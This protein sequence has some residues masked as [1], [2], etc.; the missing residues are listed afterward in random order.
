[1]T[2]TYN[3]QRVRSE[4]LSPEVLALDASGTGARR[5]L[6]RSMAARAPMFTKLAC[7]SAIVLTCSVLNGYTQVSNV[8]PDAFPGAEGY[9][10][11]AQAGRGGAVIPVTN[12]E[13]RGSGS[14][15]ECIEA[16]GP[17]NCVFRVGGVIK[18]K[19]TLLGRSENG[20]IS[21]LGQTAP[22]DGIV[23]TIEQPQQEGRNTPLAFKGTSDVLIRHI[24]V[25]PR[26]PN[27]VKN[28]D[29]LTIENSQR[30]YVDHVSASWAT[31]ENINTYSN[32]TDVTIANSIFAEGLNKHSKC[33]LLG[34]DPRTPQNLTFLRN[35]CLSNRD[36]NPDNNHYGHSCI[37]IVNNVFFNAQSEWAEVFSQYPGGTPIA[38]AGNYFKAGPSTNDLTY[39]IKAQPYARVADPHIYQD[40]N[41]TWAPPT[42]T[43]VTVAPETERFLV[44]S[45]P[46]P[47]SVSGIA[48]AAKAYDEVRTR[49]GA[50]PRD[51]LDQAWID[52]MGPAGQ[53]GKGRMV[54]APGQLP[55]MQGGA[56]YKD[57]D[58]DGMADSVEAQ[59]G[60]RPG[61][62][63]AW[64]TNTP[65]GPSH[66][67]AFMAWLSEERIAGRYPR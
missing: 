16:T 4:L 38:F 35:L 40:G 63:D 53:N 61:V 65:D 15:R 46:C 3:Q 17:R 67:D 27:T 44:S 28:V 24:R 48:P 14:L 62:S 23:L 47:L 12:L 36:R 37:E 59:F 26:L 50:F 2:A 32:A 43:I 52:E 5:S 30:V 34:S 41:V 58:H 1:M 56:P 20:S 11:T 57:E 19:R 55:P 64:A 9:G 33:S 18:L 10:K 45:P 7:L 49:S 42:K 8:A 66:F 13:D 21:I 25:R 60:A 31:D 6:R 22:G 39:A 54:T 51:S 29:A